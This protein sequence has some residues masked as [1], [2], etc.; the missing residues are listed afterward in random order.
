MA[1]FF[2]AIMGVLKSA[3]QFFLPKN[4]STVSTCCPRY[5][6]SL[7]FFLFVQDEVVSEVES[8][9]SEVNETVLDEVQGVGGPDV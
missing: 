4:H 7:S 2:N 6:L 1:R 5:S 8:V 9:E 3:K